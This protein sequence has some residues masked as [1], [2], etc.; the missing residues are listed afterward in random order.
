MKVKL[1]HKRSIWILLIAGIAFHF[2][3]LV[4]ENFFYPNFYW[5]NLLIHTAVEIA[6]T[7]ICIYSATFLISLYNLKTINFSGIFIS[8]SLISMGILD[9]FHA[10]YEPGEKFVFLHSISTFLGGFFLSLIYFK[11]QLKH[12]F[13]VF[14]FLSISVPITIGIYVALPSTAVPQMLINN[15]FS[16][17]AKILNIGGGVLFF[18]GG[19]KF[20]FGNS[21]NK[22]KYELL[23][24]AL[25]ILVGLAAAMFQSSSLF[26]FTWWGWHFLRVIAYFFALGYIIISYKEQN[27]NLLSINAELEIANQKINYQNEQLIQKN[28]NLEQMVYIT[29]HDLQEPLNTIVNFSEIIKKRVDLSLDNVTQKSFGYLIQAAETMGTLIHSL[30]EYSKIGQ[31]ANLTF[32]DTQKTVYEVLKVKSEE[33]TEIN[34]TFKSFDLPQILGYEKE[35]KLLINQLVSN[36]IKYRK[37]DEPLQVQISF[38]QNSEELTFSVNDNG[39]GIPK[40]KVTEVFKIFKRLHRKNEVEG[41]GIGLALCEKIINLFGGKIW[42]ESEIGIGSCFKFTIP[43]LKNTEID[44]RSNFN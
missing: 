19:Y 40:E 21:S 10:L 24:F 37:K 23:F 26:S 27:Q 2:V 36:A 16:T 39:I 5:D 31:D 42:V 15:E 44:S 30:L 12:L 20:Y 6:G 18:L 28:K 32:F 35:F 4:I 41:V 33:I 14:I 3:S 34:A 13:K 9:G 11:S 25:F 7:I 38:T 1:T 29:S 22:T 43:N 8:T 17:I